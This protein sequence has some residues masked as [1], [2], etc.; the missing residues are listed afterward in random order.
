MKATILHSVHVAAGARLVDFSGWEMPVQYEGILAEHLATRRSAGVF[1][2]SHMGRFLVSGAEALAFLRGALTNDA[3]KLVPGR[4]QYTLLAN[5]QGG[6]IDDAYLYQF[7]SGEYLL[8][9]NA[10]NLARDWEHL[11]ALAEEYDVVLCDRSGEWAM[12][13]LQGPESAGMLARLLDSVPGERHNDCGLSR[14]RGAEVLV[15][16]TGYAGEPVGFELIVANELAAGLWGELVAA[17]AV[18]V[19]LGARDTLRLEAG[20]PLYGHEFGTDA[21]G[22]EIPIFSCPLAKF[23]VDF[24]DPGREFVGRAALRRQVEQGTARVLRKLALVDKGIAR[25]GDRVMVGGTDRGVVTSGTMIPYWEFVAGKPGATSGRRAVALALVD[26]EVVA[27]EPL[28]V[29]VRGRDLAARMVPKFLDNRAG[30]FAVPVL[31]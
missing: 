4:A 28:A 15:M 16:R 9:V 24:T 11:K 31:D 14:Y 2:V 6:A 21:D 18:P 22:G 29:R 17:G 7:R 8:V 1:D 20:L 5:E 26:R 10:G 12:I 27:G 23:G 3:A 19:G 30:R 13:S 25:A